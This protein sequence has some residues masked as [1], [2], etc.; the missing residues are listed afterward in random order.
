MTNITAPGLSKTDAAKAATV[1]AALEI[2]KAA[3]P[4]TVFLAWA[5]GERL[6]LYHLGY[7][8]RI[9]MW[10]GMPFHMGISRARS[11]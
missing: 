8:H 3:S 10:R 1:A 2:R 11:R 5:F 4:I 6:I 7:R 9:A